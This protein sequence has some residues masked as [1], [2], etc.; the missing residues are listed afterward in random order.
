MLFEHSQDNRF[1]FARIT[2]LLEVVEHDRRLSIVMGPKRR[3]QPF[4]MAHEAEFGVMVTYQDA[5]TSAVM[6]VVCQFFVA[7]GR[8]ERVGLKRKSI[9]TNKYFKAPFRPVLYCHHHES[10]HPSMW[11]S[12]SEASDA[13]KAT[14]FEV[15]Q[16]LS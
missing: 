8:E 15:V 7:F 3:V 13:A 9:A 1:G 2:S 11:F 5:S 12:Y 6:S 10:Q 4:H 16:P 14:F